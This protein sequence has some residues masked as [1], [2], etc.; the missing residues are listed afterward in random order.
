MHKNNKLPDKFL[1]LQNQK[2]NTCAYKV[3]VFTS[4][5]RWESMRLVAWE[6]I[7]GLTMVELGTMSSHIV[8]LNI[9]YMQVHPGL[10]SSI[11]P[12]GVCFYVPFLFIVW[13]YLPKFCSNSNYFNFCHFP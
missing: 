1:V 10:D 3:I 13:I 7:S 2:K 8:T 4:V 5:V 11:L 6:N 9:S 12:L